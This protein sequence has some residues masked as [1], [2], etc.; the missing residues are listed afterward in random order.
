MR[1]QFG[2]PLVLAERRIGKSSRLAKCLI[3]SP[4]NPN[5]AKSTS[6]ESEHLLKQTKGR[7]LPVAQRP[8]GQPGAGQSC[9]QRKHYI[10]SLHYDT[11]FT[12]VSAN[13]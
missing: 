7:E 10:V 13:F 9:K 12:A 5:F 6:Q 3:S 2:D 8:E 1:R 11:A 4:P